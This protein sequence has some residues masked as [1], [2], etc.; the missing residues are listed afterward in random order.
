MRDL[1]KTPHLILKHSRYK[2]KEKDLSHTAFEIWEK[3]KVTPME[4]RH[5]IKFSEVVAEYQR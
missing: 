5:P 4:K 2:P 1:L 3:E